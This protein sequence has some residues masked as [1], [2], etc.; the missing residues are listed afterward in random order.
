MEAA[1]P[2][3]EG[4]GLQMGGRMFRLR[5][6]LLWFALASLA[7]CAG[8]SSGATRPDV[9]NVDVGMTQ[10]Q[11]LS[12]LGQPQMR[13]A[14]GPTEFLFYPTSSGSTVPVAIVDGKVTSI[15][16]AAYEIVVQSKAQSA[17]T[18]STPR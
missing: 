7:G 16:R 1:K 5:S 15:G 9:S 8:E 10:N 14:Y 2:F 3:G 17:S 12:I 13:E 6:A 11:V 4:A 18:A